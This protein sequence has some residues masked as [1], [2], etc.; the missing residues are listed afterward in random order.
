VVTLGPSNTGTLY[1]NG[2]VVNRSTNITLTP[3]SLGTATQS[4]IGRSQFTGDPYFSGR[5][6]N[7]RIYSR[8]LAAA[9]VQMLASG[10]L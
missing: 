3:S 9:A 8:A 4:W 2:A 5:M 10:H 6:D 7:F 1:V